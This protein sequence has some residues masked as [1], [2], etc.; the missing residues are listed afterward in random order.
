[1][2]HFSGKEQ[3]VKQSALEMVLELQILTY[4][5]ED[6]LGSFAKAKD[7]LAEYHA[8]NG[9]M[10]EDRK[11]QEIHDLVWDFW[12]QKFVGKVFVYARREEEEADYR[13]YFTIAEIFEADDHDYSKITPMYFLKKK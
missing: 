9:T 11:L 4:D 13:K 5:P 12:C 3:P 1:L 2:D 7:V 8:K 6:H 10:F